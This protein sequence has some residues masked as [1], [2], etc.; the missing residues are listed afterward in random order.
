MIEIHRLI[1]FGVAVVLLLSVITSSMAA[2]KVEVNGSPLTFSVPP[3]QVNGRT[4]VPLRGIFEALG[5][6]VDWDPAT[7]MISATKGDTDVHLSIGNRDATLNGKSIR[8]DTP[9]MIIDGRTMVPLR[10]V[11]EALGANVQWLEATQT[12]FITDNQN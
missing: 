12:V 4:M 6:Q 9:A 1:K 7:K 5:A 10:F 3:T 8:L 2:I 11:S